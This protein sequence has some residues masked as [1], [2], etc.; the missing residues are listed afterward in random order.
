MI[1]TGPDGALWVADM[2]R[3]VIEHP[4]WI[5]QDWQSRLNLRAGDDRGRI[6]RIVPEKG[7]LRRFSPLH[8]HTTTDL[9]AA[10]QSPNGP[11]RDLAHQLITWRNDA[12][13]EN[14]AALTKQVAEAPLPATRLQALCTLATLHK[15]DV[16][17]LRPALSDDD[18]SVRRHAIRLSAPLI[19]SDGKLAQQLEQLADDPDTQVRLQLAYTAG[20]WADADRSGRVLATIVRSVGSDPFLRAAAFSSLHDKNIGAVLAAVLQDEND[21]ASADVGLLLDQA[22]SLGAGDVLLPTL[23]QFAKP[24]PDGQFHA[25]QLQAAARVMER[26]QSSD[27]LRTQRTAALAQIEKLLTAAQEIAASDDS[28]PELRVAS[29]QLL[30]HG[31]AESQPPISALLSLLSPAYSLDVQTAAI[32]SIVVRRI[33]RRLEATLQW[34]ARLHA[35]LALRH[36]GCRVAR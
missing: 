28:S 29:L 6:Y 25:S 35:G 22:A 30:R 36:C 17:A 21:S 33:G 19:D 18:G 13:K 5:P 2:Y 27:K 11:V 3:F 15:L 16:A 1:R 20:T 7:E 4:K 26:L 9:V 14:I 34:L 31:P 8:K 32:E 23:A 24:S 10:L 12:T